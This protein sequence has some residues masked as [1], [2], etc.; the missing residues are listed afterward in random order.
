[1]LDLLERAK[2]TGFAKHYLT[3]YSM[4]LGMNAQNVFEF[5]AGF[6]SLFILEALKKTGGKLTS[7][8]LRDIEGIGL[9]KSDLSDNW[10]FVIGN[11]LEVLPKINEKFDF[12]LHDG[13]HEPEVLR[14]DLENILPKTK[15]IVL[16]H[17]TEHPRRKEY[18]F[19]DGMKKEVDRVF[20]VYD[21]V[22]LP[23]GNGL[24]IVR[25]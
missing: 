1:M 6:S 7:C 12:V 20:M 8:D 4:V 15:G 17:D 14:K 13:S 23:Y 24:T 5:G 2:H 16:I 11:S 10:E 19:L 9:T 25:V 22:T 21:K 18:K 3:L